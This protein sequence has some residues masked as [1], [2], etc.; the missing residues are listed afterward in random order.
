MLLVRPMFSFITSGIFT[1][2]FEE[3]VPHPVHLCSS[4]NLAFLRNSISKS[5]AFPVIDSNSQYVSN[6]MFGCRETSANLGARMQM[7]QSFVGNVLSS[8]SILPPMVGL[9]S[10]RYTLK[11]DSASSRDAYIPDIPPPIIA[12]APTSPTSVTNFDLLDEVNY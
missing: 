2:H 9:S 3:H 6:S 8:W 10:M 5:P 1:G 12:T 11:P 7:A 4:T